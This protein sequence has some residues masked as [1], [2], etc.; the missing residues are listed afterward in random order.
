MLR[1]PVAGWPV[2]LKTEVINPEPGLSQLNELH[3]EI[4]SLHTTNAPVVAAICADTHQIEPK[5]QNTAVE[6]TG[7]SDVAL[8][9]FHGQISRDESEGMLLPAPAFNL[10]SLQASEVLFSSDRL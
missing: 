10:L 6:A 1:E 7:T 2:V 8:P 5:L 3:R 4:D 9:Y